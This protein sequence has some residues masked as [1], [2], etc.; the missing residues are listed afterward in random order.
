MHNAYLHGRTVE[1]AVVW[2]GGD[3]ERAGQA[4]RG[5]APV[6]AHAQAADTVVVAG[7]DPHLL[8]GESVPH[9]CGRLRQVACGRC[10]LRR[11]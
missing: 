6:H 9:I 4:R 11:V 3:R 10:M 8:A 5:R 7:E 2:Q 1:S